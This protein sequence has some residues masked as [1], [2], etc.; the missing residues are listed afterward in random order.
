[1]FPTGYQWITALLILYYGHVSATNH[2]LIRVGHPKL[3]GYLVDT[4]WL[5]YFLIWLW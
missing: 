1:M 2:L 3:S 5:K 4:E